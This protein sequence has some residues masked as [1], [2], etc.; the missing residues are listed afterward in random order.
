V[1]TLY[2]CSLTANVAVRVI[3][4]AA[5]GVSVRAA[6]RVAARAAMRAAAS[7]KP[8]RLISS[9]LL[10]QLSVAWSTVVCYVVGSWW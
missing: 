10:S 5:A 8:M 4:R 1:L 2:V 9:R 3:A 7:N 6:I